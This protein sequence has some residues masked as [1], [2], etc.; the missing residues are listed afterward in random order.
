MIVVAAVLVVATLVVMTAGWVKPVVAL[1]G[2]IVIAGLLGIAPA[3][4]LF[5]GLSNG[6]VITVGAMLVIA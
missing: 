4:E 1:G 5:G 3:R 6:G 2:A